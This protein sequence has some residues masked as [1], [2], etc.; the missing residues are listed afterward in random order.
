[1]ALSELD[2]LKKFYL[3][4]KHNPNIDTSAV[5]KQIIELEQK[6]C[7]FKDECAEMPEAKPKKSIAEMYKEGMLSKSDELKG[8]YWY[9]PSWVQTQFMKELK[10]ENVNTVA[11]QTYM[12]SQVAQMLKQ[13]QTWP[14]FEQLQSLIVKVLQNNPNIG[15]KQAYDCV[16]NAVQY[17]SKHAPPTIANVDSIEIPEETVLKKAYEGLTQGVKYPPAD[18]VYIPF[19]GK[20]I[21][22]TT[23]SKP[24]QAKIVTYDKPFPDAP[25]APTPELKKMWHLSDGLA[26]VRTLQQKIRP[27]GYHLCIGGGT[28][29]N[30]NS[31]KDLDLYFLPM[32]GKFP[33]KPKELIHFLAERWGKP[34]IIG[35]TDKYPEK[36]LPYIAKLKFVF[37]ADHVFESTITKKRIDV[38]VLGAEACDL[39]KIIAGLSASLAM[40]I[41]VNVVHRK[42]S[43]K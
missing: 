27:M 17:F 13:A 1:M 2:K 14:Q 37:D 38:F 5:K 9:T 33:Q 26:L 21:S 30:G 29:N 25:P 8:E 42:K 11:K 23:P 3:V 12:E 15:L 34:E 10:G 4:A 31:E 39:D 43:F 24:G 18:P 16:Y 7:E 40:T 28:V 19:K 36:E 41:D 20:P 32:G 6:Q 22:F 35:K